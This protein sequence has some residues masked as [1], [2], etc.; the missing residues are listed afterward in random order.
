MPACTG[1]L[2]DSR[3]SE[4][5][6]WIRMLQKWRSKGAWTQRCAIG[7]VTCTRG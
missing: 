2:T 3:I 5:I 6:S 4:V 7:E 1:K